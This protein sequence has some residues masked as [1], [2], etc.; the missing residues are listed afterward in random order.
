MAD[1]LQEETESTQAESN[2]LAWF[3][4]GALIGVGI[5]ILCAPKSGTDTRQYLADKS[6]ETLEGPA[7]NLVESSKEMFERGRKLVDDAA[8]LFE[9]GRKLVKG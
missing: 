1:E 2:G 6:R 7:K 5:A 8:D 3:M 4:T 9:R